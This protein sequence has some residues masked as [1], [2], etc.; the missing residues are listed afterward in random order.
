MIYQRH[1]LAK[2][3]GNKSGL[4]TKEGPAGSQGVFCPGLSALRASEILIEYLH[5]I[6]TLESA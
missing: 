6:G 4:S 3:V 2:A 5:R 1:K